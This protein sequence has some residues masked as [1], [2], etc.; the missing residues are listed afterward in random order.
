MLD[1]TEQ[2][3]LLEQLSASVNTLKSTSTGI[4]DE[5]ET[6]NTMLTEY[7]QEAQTTT[8]RLTTAIDR[9]ERVLHLTND[10]RQTGCICCLLVVL[11]LMILVYLFA[12]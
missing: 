12:L 11:T 5:L 1:Y 8:S 6:Q 10:N 3:I 9:I 2:D 7:N 4:G